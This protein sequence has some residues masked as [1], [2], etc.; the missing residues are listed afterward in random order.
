MAKSTSVRCDFT[1]VA[2]FMSFMCGLRICVAVGD[3]IGVTPLQNSW[4]FLRNFQ[5][6]RTGN[7]NSNKTRQIPIGYWVYSCGKSSFPVGS[8][9]VSTGHLYHSY[10]KEPDGILGCSILCFTLLNKAVCK[11]GCPKTFVFIYI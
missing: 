10:I 1:G 4:F 11:G 8:C 9:I 2:N 5:C 7:H 6:R 3:G